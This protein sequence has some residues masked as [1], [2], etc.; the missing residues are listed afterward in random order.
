MRGTASFQ[1]QI[2]PPSQTDI[3]ICILWARI[4]MRLPSQDYKRADGTVPTGT[5]W[6]FEDAYAAHQLRGA[7]ELLVYRKIAK[8]TLTIESDEQLAEWQVQKRALDAFLDRWFKDHEGAFKAAFNA[9]TTDE[10]FEA[11]LSEHLEKIINKK[12]Q[13]EVVEDEDEGHTSW[14][15]GSPYRGLAVFQ[16][17]HAPIFFGRDFAIRS[18]IERLIAQ[19]SAGRVFLL[20]LGM[21]GCGKS[22]L[23]RAGVLP[24]LLRTGT[25]QGIDCWRWAIF[26]PSDGGATLLEGLAAALVDGKGALVEL[27]STGFDASKLA[28]VLQDAPIH[29][30][31]PLQ[32]ALEQAAEGFAREH[33]RSARTTARFVLIVDQLEQIFTLDRVTTEQRQSFVKAIASLSRSG[34]VW[35]VATMRTDLYPRCSDLEELIS[36]KGEDGQ[37]DLTQPTAS[38]I[39]QMIRMPA[40]AAGLHFEVDHNTHRKLD[41]ALFN[42]AANSPKALPLL[43][44]TLDELYKRKD[45]RN[46]LTWNA[47]EHELGGL[48]GAI[49]RRADEV[50][51]SL[52]SQ[53]RRVFGSVFAALVQFST[54]DV[55]SAQVGLRKDIVAKAG[56]EEL[57]KA[58]T[59]AS[60][61]VADRNQL[62]EPTIALAHEAL[63]T[64]WPKLQRWIIENGEFLRLK[65]YIVE[66]MC[67]YHEQ[68]Q[69]RDYLL[70]RGRQLQ[71]GRRLVRTHRNELSTS[72]VRFIKRSSRRAFI[73]SWGGRL[74]I[75]T[76]AAVITALVFVGIG[77]W[78]VKNAGVSMPL[79]S[80]AMTHYAEGSIHKHLGQSKKALLE[81]EK[82]FAISKTL[83]VPVL[84][85]GFDIMAFDSILELALTTN[86]PLPDDEQIE[87]V[88]AWAENFARPYGANFGKVVAAAAETMGRASFVRGRW[89]EA[90]KYYDR[91]SSLLRKI[92]AAD[93]SD[94]KSQDQICFSLM[95]SGEAKLQAAS[96]QTEGLRNLQEALQL[97]EKRATG[98]GPNGTAVE[99][100]HYLSAD[101]WQRNERQEAVIYYRKLCA[102]DP[103]WKLQETV[104]N[105][106]W[107]TW[108]KDTMEAIRQ[109]TFMR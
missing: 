74:G 98:R 88:Y 28:A 30:I 19:A 42:E 100:L 57:V 1:A 93:P 85:R 76:S 52:S 55:V 10:E 108:W 32:R 77:L 90:A 58:Y 81:Y 39:G 72:E 82:G 44:F 95:R 89:T 91:R 8:P 94:Q 104:S 53:G 20:L 68:K 63:I 2:V 84:G 17:E 9:F 61:F 12:L 22:S 103:S 16:P 56:A 79:Y 15:E 102:L 92:V 51:D 71:A 3:V 70:P 40:R 69:S 48:R 107:S 5:E 75:F 6:E 50:F 105:R 67:R 24:E 45:D 26:R 14:F 23:V 38:E 27:T 109:E 106:K 66:A 4:G 87:E 64:S 96:T 59:S 37:F 11:K 80:S 13:A 33:Q 31:P 35:V 7:P 99:C 62:G 60:L 43:E 47:Y 25:V 21:S 78:Q 83:E 41:D 86:S 73:G 18:V 101:A 29:A 34:L 97:A 49:A 46:Q 36:L 54:S 65:S